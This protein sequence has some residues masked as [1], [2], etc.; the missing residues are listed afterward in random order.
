MTRRTVKR[1]GRW[2]GALLLLV[3]ALTLTACAHGEKPSRRSS[4]TAVSTAPDSEAAVGKATPT[5]VASAKGVT[6]REQGQLVLEDIPET[7]P[8]VRERLL[9]YQNVRSASLLDW[10]AAGGVLVSTRFGETAQ[11]HHVSEPGAARRQLTFFDEPVRGAF[12]DPA[13]LVDADGPSG[14][15]FLRDSGGGENYQLHWF[16][17]RSGRARLL[18]DGTSRNQSPLPAR[19]GNRFAFVSNA[20]NGRDFDLWLVSPRSG[21]PPKLV[22][23]LKG[24]WAPVDWSPDDSKLLLLQYTSI[25]SSRLHILDLATGELTAV[26]VPEGATQVAY[27]A[28]AFL[29]N[30]ELLYASDGGGEFHSLVRHRLNVDGDG[31]REV[32]TPELRWDVEDV[33]VSRDGARFAFVVNEGGQSTLRLGRTS[34]LRGAQQVELPTGVIYGVAFDRTGRRLGVTLS[35]ARSGTDVWSVD[36]D[37]GA[38]TRWTQ[39]EIGG[40]DPSSFVEPRLITFRSAD[41]LEVPSWFYLPANATA[42]SPVPVIIDIHGGPEAQSRAG[43]SPISQHRV[44]ELGVAVLYPNVRGSSG[45]GRTW[46]TLD[47]GMKREGAVNDIGALLDWVQGQPQLDA[48]RVAVS[49]GSYG[50]FMVLASLANFGDRLRCGVDVVGISHFVT[51]LENTEAYRRDLRRVEYGDERDPEMRA[52]LERIS[53][54]TN[55]HRIDKPLFVAQ[56]LNDPRVP[57]SEAEQIVRTVRENGRPVWYFL[58]KDEGHGFARKSNRDAYL[59]AQTLFFQRCLLDS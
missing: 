3:P 44:N 16:D 5:A 28:A 45:Y 37:S 42:D 22:H 51:F 29:S 7:P 32:L 2:P 6:R 36:V 27:R 41:G 38:L 49:G 15:L 24:Y 47:D 4:T 13:E 12:F 46:L 50:G 58:A 35:G 10:D 9:Q 17:L 25:N 33:A 56:G 26:P 11:V 8:E 31:A 14:F 57:A 40:L 48:S 19:A 20:R 55:A 52:F 21:E 23:E 1:D 39:S 59:E 30:D 54:L 18:S 43:F 53:P 34:E